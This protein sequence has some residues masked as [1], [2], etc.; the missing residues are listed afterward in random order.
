M[1]QPRPTIRDI[2]SALNVSPGTVSRSLRESPGVH[3]EMR[4]RVRAMAESMGYVVRSSSGGAGSRGRNAEAGSRT[5]VGVVVGDL[6]VLNEGAVDSSYI[7]Y[8]LLAGLSQAAGELDAVVSVAFLN[9]TTMDPAADPAQEIAFLGDIDGV[10]LIY[11]LPDPFVARLV[12]VA[13]VISIEH[14]YPTLPVDVVS[15]AQS[16]DVMRAVE[17]LHQLGHR[18]IGYVADD[19]ARG[20]RLPQTQRFAGYLSGLRRAGMDFRGGD[21][22]SV[23]GLPGDSVARPALAGAVA[24]LAR[25]GVTAF[26][27][28][29]DRQAYFLW[30]ELAALGIRVP[31]D[32]SIIGIGGVTP[33]Q[34]MQQLTMY[35]TPYETLGLA[36]IS[37]L[38]QRRQRPDS[39]PV[40]IEYPSTFVEGVSVAKPGK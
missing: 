11:P 36:A 7:A 2:A 22:L 14:A 16:V 37:R 26:V 18:R 21:V 3:P 6:C 34:G 27:C 12:K 33:I 1:S 38:Q 39:F 25:D 8:H 28:S 40:F 32:V 17:R 19:A 29:T 31:D 9:A 5:R 20:N 13:N 10:V 4:R 23:P 35:R 24:N 15:P 30:K